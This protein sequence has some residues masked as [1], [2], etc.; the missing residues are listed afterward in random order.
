MSETAWLRVNTNTLEELI[1]QRKAMFRRR[2]ALRAQVALLD[3]AV[4]ALDR[5]IALT[6][7]C[8]VVDDRLSILHGLSSGQM[9][10]ILLRKIAAALE[11]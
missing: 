2:E 4:E 6:D 10:V 5:E 11:T 1:E 7:A 9:T 8:A 3:A